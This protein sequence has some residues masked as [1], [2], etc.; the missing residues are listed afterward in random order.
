[1]TQ[2]ADLI[3]IGGGP[4]G[5]EAAIRAA[6]RYEDRVGRNLI[7]DVIEREIA[8]GTRLVV[9]TAHWVAFVPFAARWPFQVQLHP[10]RHV[11]DLS[12]LTSDERDDLALVYLDLLGRIDRL[13]DVDTP[14][15]A[16]WHQASTGSLRRFGRLYLDL[17]SSRRSPD[18]LKFLAGSEAAMGAFINDI[19]PEQAANRIRAAAHSHAP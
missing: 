19:A 2:Q 6:Q 3:V 11:A 4:G 1:M 18:K 8:D 17:F 14:Y 7:E 5:Y 9:T 10:R 12:E 16:A 15:I 13:F